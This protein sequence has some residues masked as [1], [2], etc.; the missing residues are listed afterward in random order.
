MSTKP[1]LIDAS[2]LSTGPVLTRSRGVVLYMSPSTYDVPQSVTIAAD[3]GEVVLAFQYLDREEEHELHIDEKLIFHV[4]RNSG[5]VLRILAKN[6]DG[7][8]E[9]AAHIVSGIDAQLDY[10]RRDNQKMNYAIIRDLLTHQL[11]PALAGV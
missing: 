7:P 3:R 2:K 10:L 6:T 5:K 4:G 9:A 1:I 11:Q 8:R